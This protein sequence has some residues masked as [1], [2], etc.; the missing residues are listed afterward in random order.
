MQGDPEV[1]EFLNE[2]LTAELTA[3]NQYFLHA[4]MQE[5][6]GWTKLAEYTRAESFDEMRH[7]E[8]LTDRIL[9]LEGL[10]NYQRLF[11][12]RVGQT[13]TEM[14][15]ADRQI[16]VEAIDRLRRGIELMRAKGD[17]T[18]ANI[19]EDIL[20]DEEHH[21]DYLDTQLDLIEKLGEA[22]YISRQIEQKA[23]NET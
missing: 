19:F 1:I 21:I 10:P 3:I 8:R 6:N 16:E 5:H 12:V 11:H 18:S 15:K 7:A 2:Q 22:L 13:L 14:F 4:K 9:F 20:A 17:I 23:A